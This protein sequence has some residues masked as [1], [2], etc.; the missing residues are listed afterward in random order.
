MD[1]ENKFLSHP[2]GGVVDYSSVTEAPGLRASGEQLERLYHR[3]RFA[4]EFAGGRDVLEVACGTGI[5]LGLL[6]RAARSVVGV[7]IDARNL[8]IAQKNYENSSVGF[9]KMDAQSLAFPDS[10][11][12]LVVFFE[13]IYYLKEP[14]RVIAEAYRVLRESGRLIVGT[15]NCDWKDFHASPFAERYLNMIELR[16]LLAESFRQVD[17]YGSFPVA[18]KGLRVRFVSMLKRAAVSLDLIPGSLKA[19][20]YLKRLVFGPLTPLP[21]KLH[22]DMAPYT[23]PLMI[24]GLANHRSFKIIYAVATK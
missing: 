23:A 15:V 12:D 18:E 5:G 22:E 3:Y 21:D 7:D 6:T 11:F 13:A 2:S 17:I 8:S 16:S 4:L 14:E 20:S 24:D 19:R 1:P 10:S 9:R